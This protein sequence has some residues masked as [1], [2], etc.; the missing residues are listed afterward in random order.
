MSQRL[1]LLPG[2]YAVCQLRAGAS[3]QVPAQAELW[4]LT[5]TAAEHSLVCAERDVP[6]D[7]VLKIEPGWR[8]FMLR[9]PFD[10]ALTGI[11]ASVLNP[12]AAAGVGIFALS[13]FDTD[14]LLVKADRLDEA[15][16]ALQRAGHEVH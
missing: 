8:A 10:F 4:S 5:R 11:L 3:L 2:D 6:P 15:I 16:T 9:G 12:L 7:G 13:T 1:N 14:Y